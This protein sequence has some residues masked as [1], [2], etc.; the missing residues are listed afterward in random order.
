MTDLN[1]LLNSI[2]TIDTNAKSNLLKAFKAK[3]YYKGE[4]LL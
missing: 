3:T 4:F 2:I 1:N